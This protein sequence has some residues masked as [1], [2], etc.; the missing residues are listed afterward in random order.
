MTFVRSHLQHSLKDLINMYLLV[1]FSIL[2]KTKTVP[3]FTAPFS[4][5]ISPILLVDDPFG[6]STSI[7]L[8][9]Y[10]LVLMRMK[11]T[12][13]LNHKLKAVQ[14]KIKKMRLPLFHLILY[15]NISSL[16]NCRPYV[17]L[18]IQHDVKRNKFTYLFN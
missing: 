8:F 12:H 13:R 1:N 11:Y 4:S 16:L 6:I 7:F 3:F 18:S 15:Q 10:Q 17:H 2:Y 14:S 9:R 5:K